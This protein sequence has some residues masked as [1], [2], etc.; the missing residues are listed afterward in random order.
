MGVWSLLC[1]LS[2]R[3]GVSAGPGRCLGLVPLLG[4]KSRTATIVGWAPQMRESDRPTDTLLHCTAPYPR[5]RAQD[6]SERQRHFYS[7]V[8]VILEGS[9][10]SS[11][12]TDFL[13]PTVGSCH[14]PSLPLTTQAAPV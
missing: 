14:L 13:D 9:L 4:R 11:R 6:H 12:S 7:T 8:H 5:N 2:Q 1:G 3:A 10:V